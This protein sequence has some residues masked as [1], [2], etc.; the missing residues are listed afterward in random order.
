[1]VQAHDRQM[2]SEPFSF[3]SCT[4]GFPNQSV[5]IGPELSAGMIEAEKR[6]KAYFLELALSGDGSP[7]TFKR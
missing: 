2:E 7:F 1:V 3:F 6:I 4:P 5:H